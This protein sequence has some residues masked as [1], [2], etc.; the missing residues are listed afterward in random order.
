MM[1]IVNSSFPDPALAITSASTYTLQSCERLSGALN[2]VGPSTRRVLYLNG[3]AP[4]SGL[5]CS[6]QRAEHMHSYPQG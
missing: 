4:H 6:Q 3:A 1:L 2:A 5:A